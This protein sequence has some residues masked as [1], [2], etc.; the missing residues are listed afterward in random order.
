MDKLDPLKHITNLKTGSDEPVTAEDVLFNYP[1]D[2]S[3]PHEKFYS[4]LSTLRAMNEYAATLSAR[5]KEL[6]SSQRERAVG[7][8]EWIRFDHNVYELRGQFETKDWQYHNEKLTTA[9]LYD[10][11]IEYL[12]KKA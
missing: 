10:E 7:F 11:Y 12:N 6:E 9:E 5:V 1:W 2:Q 8:A 4:E 3:D